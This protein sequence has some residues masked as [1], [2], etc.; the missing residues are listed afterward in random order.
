M[1]EPVALSYL[2]DPRDRAL[3][4]TAPM[5]MQ[6][7]HSP[8]PPLRPGQTRYVA[9]HDGIYLEARSQAVHARA[10]YANTPTLPYGQC[11][12]FIELPGG[13]IPPYMIDAMKKRACEAAPKEWAGA[14]VWRDGGYHLVVPEVVSVSGHHISYR[15]DSLP[16]DRLVLD[17]HSHGHCTPFFSSTD[18]ASDLGG[19]YIAL[20]LGHC[21]AP[22]QVRIVKWLVMHG[23]FFHLAD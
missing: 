18:D 10:K 12:P 3:F 13:P 20:V 4:S 22:P 23:R 17:V 9:G 14:V 19:V 8:L 21:T 2:D 1:L 5:V 11:V 16:E 7:R 6:G 15:R